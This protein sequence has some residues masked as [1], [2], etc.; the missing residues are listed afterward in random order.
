MSGL[1]HRRAGFDTEWRNWGTERTKR[2]LQ[3]CYMLPKENRPTSPPRRV[4]L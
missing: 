3:F 2:E 1:K 4:T